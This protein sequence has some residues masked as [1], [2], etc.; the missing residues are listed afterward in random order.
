MYLHTSVHEVGK[1]WALGNFMMAESMTDWVVLEDSL[2][3]NL[4]V[5]QY[6]RLQIKIVVM[7]N[8]L[9]LDLYVTDI[10]STLSV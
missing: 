3:Y 4:S 2:Y 6:M 10:I 7:F 1:A 9:L 8:K 5:V